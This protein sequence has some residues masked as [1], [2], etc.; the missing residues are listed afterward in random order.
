MNSDTADFRSLE[1]LVELLEAIGL[2]LHAK[3]R[4]SGGESGYLWH[5]A[6]IIRDA[7]RMATRANEEPEL[8]ALF[9]DGDQAGSIP[10]EAQRDHFLSLLGDYPQ[11]K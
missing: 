1:E 3:N 6:E 11:K 5:L 4:I 9:G 10:E 8:L 7:G 2:R